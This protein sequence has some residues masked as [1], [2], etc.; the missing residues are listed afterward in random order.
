MKTCP[1]CGV[2]K[3]IEEFSINKGG[4]DGLRSWCRDCV[5]AD[6][7]ARY[8]A[9][10]EASRAKHRAW[11]AADPEKATARSKAWAKANPE[12]A[13]AATKAWMVANPD[14]CRNS[15]L[16]RDFGITIEDF[17]MMLMLQAGVCAICQKPE[18]AGRNLSVDHNHDTGK[19]RGLLCDACNTSLGKFGDST[20]TLRRAIAYLEK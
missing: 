9:T 19:V 14:R 12:K 18:R 2:K 6:S 11:R 20:E 8:W 13:K 17:Q 5:N 4:L 1:K 3:S 16:L 7:R 10:P 15:Q